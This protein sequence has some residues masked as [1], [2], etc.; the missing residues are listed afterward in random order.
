M[1]QKIT[2][3]GTDQAWEEWGLRD[4]YY[5]VITHPKFRRSVLSDDAK[6]EFFE[7]GSRHVEHVVQ[8]IRRCLDTA[9]SPKRVLE[10]G[11]G[12]G[13]TLPALA[14]IAESVVGVDVS[15]SMLREAARNCS[16]RALEN[17]QVLLSD[18]SLSQLVGQFDFIHSFIVFQHIPCD[19]GRHLLSQ[20]LRVLAPNGIGAVHFTYSKSHFIDSWGL[21]PGLPAPGKIISPPRP[22]DADPEM[23]MNPYNVNQLLF[24][25]QRAGIRRVQVEFTDHGGELG[26]FLFFQSV[27][28]QPSF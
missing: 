11:C 18:D 21:P 7:S 4:P 23:Q 9:F 1:K 6:S 10:F 20:L 13:R 16:E 22:A 28:D 2:T 14:K 3:T 8:T 5:G 25:L 24:T 19:R 15:S 27:D 26:V 17:V 12:V